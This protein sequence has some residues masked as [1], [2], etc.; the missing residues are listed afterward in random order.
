MGTLAYHS[1]FNTA[2]LRK[3]KS[4][5][6]H[7]AAGSLGHFAIQLAQN[8]NA[9]IYATVNSKHKR[10]LLIHQY[11]ISEDHIF[12][13]RNTSFDQKIMR[14]T[15]NRGVKIVLNTLQGGLLETS[16]SCIASFGRFIQIETQASLPQLP[17]HLLKK[18]CSFINV[19][20]DGMINEAPQD[21]N[22]SLTAMLNLITDSKAIMIPTPFMV[23]PVSQMGEALEQMQN[24]K[25]AGKT[26]IRIDPEAEVQVR[27]PRFESWDR[28]LMIF[29]DNS[30]HRARVSAIGRCYL[31][32]YGWTGWYW[33]ECREM[34]GRSRSQ[35]PHIIITFRG[36][37][38]SC[39]G[40][41]QKLN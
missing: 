26:V 15:K 21:W 38:R 35:K 25:H 36:Y 24:G 6:I 9:E 33:Q 31:C 37:A 41:R 2:R 12:N 28:R 5:L 29:S 40:A 19:N 27:S 14:I 32:N 16:W 39:T 3:K 7:G 34:D 22:N 13:S 1:L 4:I 8:I 11:R 17:R 23:Y 10:D 30:R 18:N 20:M